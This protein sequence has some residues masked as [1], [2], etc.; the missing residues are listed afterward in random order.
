[1]CPASAG[2]KIFCSGLITWSNYTKIEGQELF[3]L[4]VCLCV[5]SFGCIN[6]V[7]KVRLHKY[8]VNTIHLAGYCTQPIFNSLKI[9]TELSQKK[10]KKET[11]NI[12]RNHFICI[13]DISY[14]SY[15]KIY[16]EVIILKSKYTFE[17]HVLLH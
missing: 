16:P 7:Q 5:R 8:Q 13:L 12:F 3:V 14:I 6:V 11:L 4:D 10:Y 17:K 9:S 15:L 1:M 2:T